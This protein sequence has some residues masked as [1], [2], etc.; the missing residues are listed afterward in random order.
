MELT[1]SFLNLL[2]HFSSTFTD[3]TFQTFVQ[4]CSGW[5]LSHRRRYITEEA[6]KTCPMAFGDVATGEDDVGDVASAM[7]QNPAG[8]QL[9]EGLESGIGEGGRKM[10]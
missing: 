10:G 1:H 7:R 5:V 8:A 2:S 4:L 6:M 3:P 9:H